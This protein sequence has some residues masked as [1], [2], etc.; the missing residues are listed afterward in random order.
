M[1][2]P[3]SKSPPLW[4]LEKCL[5]RSGVNLVCGV[6]EAGRGPL[7]GPVAAA[8]VIFPRGMFVNGVD[9]SK[10][11]SPKKRHFLYRRILRSSLEAGVG[12]VGPDYIDRHNILKASLEAMRMAVESLT[13][14]P[15]LVLV[16]GNHPIPDIDLPQRAV[17][18][19]DRKSHAVAA[20]SILA[21]VTRDLIMVELD[22]LYPEYDFA[23]NK[24]YPTP[25][26][27]EALLRF[28]PCPIHR[29]SFRLRQRKL[30]DWA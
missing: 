16:D 15:K 19:G 8:A 11:L 10:K 3:K 1:R 23:N 7:A 12:I 29:K 9:D 13:V 28:G 5:Y 6:D 27:G 22:S 25:A 18:A 2:K 17:I 26:H 4:G 21:K 14:K 24:G 30:I 20:A